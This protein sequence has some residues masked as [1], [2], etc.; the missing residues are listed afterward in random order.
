[1][2]AQAILQALMGLDARATSIATVV[3]AQS[4]FLARIET[5][6]RGSEW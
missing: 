5:L 2:D 6:T 4:N 3:A 1:M